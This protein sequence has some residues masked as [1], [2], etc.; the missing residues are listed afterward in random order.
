MALLGSLVGF[1]ILYETPSQRDIGTVAW[2]SFLCGPIVVILI[3]EW[4]LLFSYLFCEWAVFCSHGNRL[5]GP[6]RRVCSEV[7]WGQ[8][9]WIVVK[10]VT[11][12]SN[13]ID[14]VMCH[15]MCC[16]HVCMYAQCLYVY[17]RKSDICNSTLVCKSHVR[18]VYCKHYMY[19]LVYVQ[20]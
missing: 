17:V 19:V 15:G 9:V 5:F 8:L 6:M 12:N 10:A 1:L 2:F 3:Y 18:T 11:L 7:Y 13:R 4:K 20:Y 14:V 16:V